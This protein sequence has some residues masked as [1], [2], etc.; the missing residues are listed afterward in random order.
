MNT[1]VHKKAAFARFSWPW[2]GKL[3]EV[4]SQ[5][6]RAGHTSKIRILQCSVFVKINLYTKTEKKMLTKREIKTIPVLGNGAKNLI[7]GEPCM[8]MCV[9]EISILGIVL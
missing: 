9:F 8:K 3:V 5:L 2:H 1:R 4:G 6:S 7:I